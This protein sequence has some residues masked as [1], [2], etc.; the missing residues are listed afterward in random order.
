MTSCCVKAAEH[1]TVF[2]IDFSVVCL[3]LKVFNDSGE[4]VTPR[5]LR[6][7]DPISIYDSAGKAARR[8][9]KMPV[10]CEE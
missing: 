7:V 4:D 1:E 3:L 8:M 6:H 5:P 9:S 10:C 2:I